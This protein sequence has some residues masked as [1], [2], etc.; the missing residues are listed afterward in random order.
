MYALSRARLLF[1]LDLPRTDGG[2]AAVLPEDSASTFDVL[3]GPDSA[4]CMLLSA[5]AMF[6]RCSARRPR[7][8]D[9]R[10]LE[11]GSTWAG[12]NGSIGIHTPL[13]RTLH[14]LWSTPVRGAASDRVDCVGVREFDVG[15][16]AVVRRG[17]M[18]S[19]V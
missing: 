5:S 10:T 8:E 1:N 19:A 12:G 6:R 15:V 17:M 2:V 11:S 13:R 7:E 3:R 14:L 9:G 16:A 18:A 4:S